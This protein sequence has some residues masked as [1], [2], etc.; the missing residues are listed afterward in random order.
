MLINLLQAAILTNIFAST[1]RIST[2]LLMAALGELVTERSGVMN[3][4]VEGTM[5]MGA[6]IGFLVAYKTNS[7]LL[8]IGGAI[9]VGA[10]MGLLMV[11]MA[12]TLKVDQTVTG[13]AIN[14]LASG[15]SYFWY[16]VVFEAFSEANADLPV[17][18]I[19]PNVQIP[20]LSELPYVGEILFNHKILTYV[21]FAMVPIVWY[22]L[23]KTKYG[24][25]IR[26]VGEN[27]R[28]VDMK[29]LSVSRLQYF[30]VIFG[31]MMSGLAGSF[32]TLGSS[33]RFLP[34]IS[35]GR[36]W[37]AIVIVIAGNWMPI[38]IM[39]ATL[40]FAFLDALQLQ[41]QGIGFQVP[42]QILLALPYLFAILALAASR[43]RSLAPAWLGKPYERE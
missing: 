24:L 42:Y 10:L 1:I 38:R 19:L 4:G 3:L 6:W 27:P 20:F 21:A 16:K 2:P 39:L 8:A 14:L 33:S 23:Y 13:L 40:I 25:R 26:G 18:A 7:I 32:L 31:G 15:V 17:I 11:F 37:L 43:T 34:E 9:L 29:G 35:A 41:L 12:T 5:L 22:F 36:G 30:A 28:A